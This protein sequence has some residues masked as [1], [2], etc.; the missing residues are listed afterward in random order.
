MKRTKLVWL[1]GIVCVVF[2]LG[3]F[4]GVVAYSAKA[5]EIELSAASLWPA[6]HP[7]YQNLIDAWG[8]EIAKRTSGKV[9]I[10]GYPTGTLCTAKEIYEA[11]TNG[12]A[13]IGVSCFAYTRG[14]FPLMEAVDLPLG[15]GRGEVATKVANDIYKKHRPQELSDTHVCFLHA[16]GPGILATKKPVRQIEDLKGMKIRCTGLAAKVIRK[17]GGVPVAMPQAAAYEAL[18]KGVVEGTA[19][20]IEVLEEWKQG[21]LINHV[22]LNYS[23]AYTTTFFTVVNLNKWNSLPSAV[24]TIITDVSKEWIEKQGKLWDDLDRHAF[25]WLR[26]KGVEII[27]QTPSESLRWEQAVLPLINEYIEKKGAMGLP[28]NAVVKDIKGLVKQYR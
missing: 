17:L 13:D 8:A 12:I 11:V 21:E 20:P 3:G 6:T 25:P 16:H 19:C 27:E 15:Y 5:A 1:I 18:Q 23:S 4:P 22:T 14:R 24:Q 9:K 26:E 28:A 7:N 10:I 2:I